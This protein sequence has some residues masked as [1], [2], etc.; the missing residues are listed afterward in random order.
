M[1]K[2]VAVAAVFVA[3]GAAPFAGRVGAQNGQPINTGSANEETIAVFG[4][5]PYSQSLLAAAPLLLESINSD[6]KV[7]LVIHV[8][9]IH[10][11]SMPCTGADLNPLPATSVPHWNEGI[12]GIFEQ[13]KDPVIY[14]PGDN[15]WTDCHKTN[16]GTS[17]DPLKELA[18][19]RNLFFAN[20]GYS[21]G[22]QKKRVISQALNF[23]P[24]HPSDAQFVENVM[25][26]ESQVVFVT[27]NVP[28]SN[29]DTLP[30]NGGSRTVP[31]NAPYSTSNPFVPPFLNEPARAHE[32]SERDPANSRWLARAFALAEANNAKAVMVIIQADMW[33]STAALSA[34]QPL[35][36]QLGDLS[37]HFGRPVLLVNG[38]SHLFE[39]DNPLASPGSV[40][41]QI[42]K[43][44]NA[45]P[46]LTRITVQGSTNVPHEWLRLT[47]DPRSHDVFSWTN[48]IYCDQTTCPQ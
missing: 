26:E 44:P 4:D 25:W 12:F 24:M 2:L 8:G 14:T 9:D 42:H 48:V 41:G 27:L 22:G 19:V 30:W 40:I 37:L 3:I 11:G 39:V 5:W 29:N 1:K 47:I 34:Y 16:Q 7:R 28:G 6:P 18:A 15:E 33:D 13:F 10:S 46:N 43:Y 35:V 21:L 17:G 20:P 38:D 36:F 45:V 31:G 23:D 32:V